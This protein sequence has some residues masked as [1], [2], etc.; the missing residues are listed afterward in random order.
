M[1]EQGTGKIVNIGSVSAWITTPFAGTY[2]AAKAAVHNISHALRMELKPFGIQVMLVAPG[3]IRSNFGGNSS[4]SVSH[5]QLKIYTR[6][7]REGR[8]ADRYRVPGD[9]NRGGEGRR[10]SLG[11]S[12]KNQGITEGVPRHSSDDLPNELPP[13]RTHQHEIVEEPGSKPTFRAPYRLSPTELT[14]MKKQIEY[15]LTKGLIRPSTSPYGAPVLFTPKPD[16]SL[17]MCIDYRALTSRPSRINI[18]Y[19][20]SMTCLTSFGELRYFPNWMCG[21]DT[22]RYGWR[23][24]LST[25]CFPNSVRIV[26]VF[27]SCRSDSPT[28]RQRSKPK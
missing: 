22:G 13:Y 7:I 26:R 4:S 11:N 5:L 18:R 17:R 1:V 10:E 15:L 28:R 21:P 23:T 12:R 2:C 25:N 27:W 16:G 24:T 14:D 6:T 9:S 3:A 19:R 8:E 20:E